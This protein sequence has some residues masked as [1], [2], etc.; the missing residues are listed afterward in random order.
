MS[1][2]LKR[3]QPWMWT[4]KH[5]YLEFILEFLRH[6]WDCISTH[7][8]S[9]SSSI[10][11]L[12]FIRI[13]ECQAEPSNETVLYH[14]M[15]YLRFNLKNK[16]E[17]Q[18]REN[19][20]A[21]ISRHICFPRIRSSKPILVFCCYTIQFCIYIFIDI[22]LVFFLYNLQNCMIMYFIS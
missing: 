1:C 15:A 19:N 10:F 21:Q 16:R 8:P 2:T 3:I 9:V 5:G 20:K 12:S 6:S 14:M 22:F 4:L 11:R 17:K 13:S 18:S 7:F